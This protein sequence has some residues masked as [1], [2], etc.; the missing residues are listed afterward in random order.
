MDEAEH[1]GCVDPSRE[2]VVLVDA[3]SSQ[4]FPGMTDTRFPTVNFSEPQPTGARP[5]IRATELNKRC[6]LLLALQE[7]NVQGG[8]PVNE[9]VQEHGVQFDDVVNFPAE[10]VGSAVTAAPVSAAATPFEALKAALVPK[11]GLRL[12]KLLAQMR[13]PSDTKS[14]SE[15]IAGAICDKVHLADAST[16]TMSKLLAF[17]ANT[18]SGPLKDNLRYTNKLH[19][20]VD[21]CIQHIDVTATGDLEY[22]KRGR[23]NTSHELKVNIEIRLWSVAAD[24]SALLKRNEV[25]PAEFKKRVRWH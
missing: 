17:V 8:D 9:T 20:V 22:H 21:G 11:L 3:A 1:P 23:I 19:D 2:D 7:L 18:S 13:I 12:E 5:T 14:I 15:G 16:G 6:T 24:F 25:N 10:E 4:Q